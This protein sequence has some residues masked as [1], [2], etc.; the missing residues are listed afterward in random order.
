MTSKGKAKERTTPLSSQE[1]I[2]DW[3]D[4]EKNF[5]E[6]YVYV[7]RYS[8]ILLMCRF[9]P[10]FILFN[11]NFSLL[12][13]LTFRRKYRKQ[14]SKKEFDEKKTPIRSDFDIEI[15]QPRQEDFEGYK[16]T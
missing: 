12:D 7:I 2:I 14:V 9:V 10:F 13:R 11:L 8:P 16:V 1:E 6:A 4:S 5:K 3:S 15:T